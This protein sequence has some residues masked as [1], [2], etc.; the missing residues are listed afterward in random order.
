MSAG[1][2][3]VRGFCHDAGARGER[4]H[5]KICFQ[6][7]RTITSYIIRRNEA[8]RRT[9]CPAFS[10]MLWIF[11]WCVVSCALCTTFEVSA[12]SLSAESPRARAIRYTQCARRADAI[13]VV[14]NLCV[15]CAHGCFML[16]PAMINVCSSEICADFTQ[17]LCVFFFLF[18]LV[19]FAKYKTFVTHQHTTCIYMY[20]VWTPD[21]PT[22]PV[23]LVSICR[24]HA[25]AS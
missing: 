6:I 22:N 25:L 8:M 15:N 19:L 9:G 7:S 16:H 5:V 21:S 12:S 10:F 23:N 4:T 13:H 11:R 20:I 3:F 17:A 14:C 24:A 18:S 1:V 2:L